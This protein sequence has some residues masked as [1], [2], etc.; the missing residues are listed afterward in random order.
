MNSETWIKAL[1]AVKVLCAIDKPAQADYVQ[2]MYSELKDKYTDEQ[3]QIAARE[4]ATKEELYGNYPSLRVWLKHCPQTLASQFVNDKQK[5]AFLDAVSAVMW[6][7]H[8]IYDHSE[9]EKKIKRTFGWKGYNAFKK[10]GISLQ[11]LRGYHHAS[12]TQKNQIIDKFS[13]AWDEASDK[14]PRP[15][16]GV[17]TNESKIISLPKQDNEQKNENMENALAELDAFF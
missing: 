15:T 8:I 5:T 17:I 10:T 3:I 16:V 6:L 13:R 7:D 4:I 9:T 2:G 11:T 12:E 1:H 14:D